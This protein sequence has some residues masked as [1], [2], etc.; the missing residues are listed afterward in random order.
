MRRRYSC[1]LLSRVLENTIKNVLVIVQECPIALVT[2]KNAYFTVQE[3]PFALVTDCVHQ[4]CFLAS[5]MPTRVKLNQYSRAG[6]RTKVYISVWP[7]GESLLFVFAG[8]TKR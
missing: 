8:L 3:C 7:K 4:E 5:R 1:M 2:I 6:P